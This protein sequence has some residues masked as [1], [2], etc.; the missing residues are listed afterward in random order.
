MD[1]YNWKIK[2]RLNGKIDRVTNVNS[3]PYE[4]TMADFNKYLKILNNSKAEI[5]NIEIK[6][7]Q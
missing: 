2:Y 7:V 1:S 4:E 3:M 6:Q 5:I